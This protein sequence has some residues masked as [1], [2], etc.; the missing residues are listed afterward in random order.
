VKIIS[1]AEHPG[2]IRQTKV[3]GQHEQKSATVS[4]LT[5]GK[6]LQ[7]Q[8]NVYLKLMSVSIFSQKILISI[9]VPVSKFSNSCVSIFQKLEKT[10]NCNISFLDKQELLIIKLFFVLT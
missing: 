6:K 1:F 5:R 8:L 9:F 7:F 2:V 4:V 3:H 10:E